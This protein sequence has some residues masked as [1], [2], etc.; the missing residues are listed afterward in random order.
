MNV[1]IAEADGY[2]PEAMRLFR[3]LGESRCGAFGDRAAFLAALGE[4]EVL[5]IR[6]RHRIDA[7]ALNAAPRLRVIVSPTTG[8]D[9]IDLAEASERGIA[10]LSLKG[11][12]E[13]LQNVTATAELTWA[14]ILELARRVGEA[15]QDVLRGKW[16][17]DAWIGRSL[18]GRTLG[19][20]G[21]GRLG[22]IVA[23]YGHAFRMP[24]IAHDPYV[25]RYPAHVRAVALG[26]L[27]AS[28][29]ILS[30]HVPLSTETVHLIGSAEIA[31]MKPGAW[32]VNTA[33][34]KIVDEAALLAALRSGAIAAAGLDVLADETA[35]AEGW[36]KSNALRAYAQSHSNLILTPHIGGATADAMADTEV[37]MARKLLAHLGLS[38][39]RT[40]DSAKSRARNE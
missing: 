20:L 9:H 29:D 30:I 17:R 13:F 25:E 28:A 6:L 10:V 21:F 8:L 35:E 19:V 37:F 11:E 2:S 33:R 22:R 15:H 3:A 31:R 5:V 27:L 34:G 36:L 39:S 4:V 12:T 24:V 23:D 40:E 1:L 26:D 16:N 7:E 38:A 18:K 32:V 14:L